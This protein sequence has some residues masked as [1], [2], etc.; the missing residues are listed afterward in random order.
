[1]TSLCDFQIW[2]SGKTLTPYLSP[3]WWYPWNLCSW[4]RRG[5]LEPV[6]TVIVMLSLWTRM[7]PRTSPNFHVD[8]NIMSS[9][10]G[11]SAVPDVCID[12]TAERLL[13]LTWFVGQSCRMFAGRFRDYY[14]MSCWAAKSTDSTFLSDKVEIIFLPM[15]SEYDDKEMI[16]FRVPP[17]SFTA[18]S[19]CCHVLCFCATY[20]AHCR[21]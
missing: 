5:N 3:A 6:A 9:R 10:Y 2:S 18:T 16:W 12:L 4:F 7:V 21:R 11:E 19:C 20:C 13:V 1:M 17:A 8:P 15:F 14:S